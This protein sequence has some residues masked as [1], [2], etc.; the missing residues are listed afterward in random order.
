MLNRKDLVIVEQ[1]NPELKG[2]DIEGLS[3]N[4]S[5]SVFC[6]NPLLGNTAQNDRLEIVQ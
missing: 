6:S 2:F 5:E 3:Q 4:P 1:K